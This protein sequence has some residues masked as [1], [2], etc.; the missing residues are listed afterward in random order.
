MRFQSRPTVIS[1]Q[2]NHPKPLLRQPLIGGFIG[3]ARLND[4][5]L[6][7]SLPPCIRS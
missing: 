4:A 6:Q 5:L 3:F 7:P 1:S 2:L